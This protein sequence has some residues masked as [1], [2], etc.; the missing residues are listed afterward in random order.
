MS[1]SLSF[2]FLSSLRTRGCGFTFEVQQVVSKNLGGGLIAEAFP[3][4]II[5]YLYEARKVL[6]REGRQVG[7]ARQGAAQ[8]ADGVLD[9][10]LLPGRVGLTEEGFEAERMEGVMPRKLRPLSKVIV[11]RHVGGKGARRVAMAWAIGAA[12]LPGGRA[13]IN[14]REWRSWEGQDGL[15]RR[16]GTTSDRPPNGPGYGDPRPP[17]AAPPAGGAER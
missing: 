2:L 12:A 1:L 4:R 5:V 17:P 6:L 11:W 3:R 15:G 7:L 16:S 14:R 8:A 10:A 9:A 13:A